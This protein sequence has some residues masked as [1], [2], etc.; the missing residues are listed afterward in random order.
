MMDRRKTSADT[1]FAEHEDAVGKRQ[2]KKSGGTKGG[3]R[4]CG[5]SVVVVFSVRG[6]WGRRRGGGECRCGGG[7]AYPMGR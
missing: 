2:G 4:Q 7:G 6:E 5:V 3:T 1:S